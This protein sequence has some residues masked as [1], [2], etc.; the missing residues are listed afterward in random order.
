MNDYFLAM[1]FPRAIMNTIR[2]GS[3]PHDL[4][5]TCRYD[6]MTKNLHPVKRLLI[7]DENGHELSSFSS[8]HSAWQWSRTCVIQLKA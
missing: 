1:I 4:T 6:I 8:T 3:Q 5:P 7:V 2:T